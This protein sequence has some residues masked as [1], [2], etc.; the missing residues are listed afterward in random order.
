MKHKGE[1]SIYGKTDMGRVRTNNEDAF[2]AQSLWD[3]DTFLAIA[4]DGVGGY[5]GGEI[6]ADIARKTIPEFLSV[7]SNG[8]RIELLKQAVTA[9]NNA[10]FEAREADP[11]HGQMSCVLTA[12]II[13]IAQQEISMAHVG[14]SRLYSFYHGELKKLSH[15]HSLIGYREEIG[16]LTEEEA[17]HHPQRNVIGRDL[18]S[19]KHKANDD[20]FI[21]AQ[22]FPLLPN[23]TLL[24]CSDGLSDMITSST[25]T[26]VLSQSDSLEEK[27]D[28]LI[29]AALEAGGKDN[30]TVVLFEY[31]NDEPE[32]KTA[33]AKKEMERSV[34]FDAAE[35]TYNQANQTAGNSSRKKWPVIVVCLILVLM[36]GAFAV[37]N[38]LNGKTQKNKGKMEEQQN[39][40]SDSIV[41]PQN[42]IDSLKFQAI[43]PAQ[44]TNAENYSGMQS[45][46]ES[47]QRQNDSL[48]MK[49]I[50]SESQKKQL[51]NKVNQFVEELDVLRKSL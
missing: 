12:A 32:T 31:L 24:F 28:A 14:D 4:I 30:V 16:D 40:C 13:D 8:E 19:Q 27:A 2:V 9:A 35:E 33:E 18:G 5:E 21:E 41:L 1:I 48:R 20:E 45:Q 50:E 51:E 11:E 29:K 42:K 44:G 36:A 47:L 17:M 10:I 46:I 3:E 39:G 38:G 37:F 49:L 23:T 43:H 7:S 26:A 25:I 22:V 34:V 15:D 6:A